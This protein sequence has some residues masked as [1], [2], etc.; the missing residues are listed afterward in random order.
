MCVHSYSPH[1]GAK[2][3][4][5]TPS[6]SIL[7]A[8]DLYSATLEIYGHEVAAVAVETSPEES[9]QQPATVSTKA[10]SDSNAATPA[11]VVDVVHFDNRID[12]VL[13]L[14]ARQCPRLGILVSIYV[15]VKFAGSPLLIISETLMLAEPIHSADHSR[16]GGRRDAPVDCKS[17]PEPSS[18]VRA[19]CSRPLR[20]RLASQSRMDVPV[21]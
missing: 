8:V 5:Q 19:P 4:F 6:S 13:L 16:H 15:Y 9:S 20:V 10:V 17:G 14:M 7:R 2:M 18:P 21:L 3:Q 11:D 1:F 12:S